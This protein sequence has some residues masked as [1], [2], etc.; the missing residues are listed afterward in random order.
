MA[1]VPRTGSLI[2]VSSMPGG[3]L[4]QMPEAAAP[5]DLPPA[6]TIASQRETKV[7]VRGPCDGPGSRRRGAV[8]RIALIAPPWLAVP[9]VSYGGTERIID[10]LA[11][12]LIEIGHDVVLLT[13]GDSTCPVPKRVTLPRAVGTD[14][15]SPAWE[16]RNVIAAYDH[17][18]EAQVDVVHDH[19]LVGPFFAR[20]FP[21]LPV[22]TTNHGPFEGDLAD[23]YR[24][25]TELIPVVAISHNQAAAAPRLRIPVEAVIHHGVHL[26]DYPIGTGRGGYAAFVGRMNPTKGVHVACQLA[27]EAAIPLRIA[28]KMRERDEHDY[29]EGCIRP[30][31]GGDIEYL[32]ELDRGDT[33]RLMGDAALSA[34]PHRLARAIWAGHGRIPGHGHTGGRNAGRSGTRDRRRRHHRLAPRRSTTVARCTPLR[35]RPRPPR[36]PGRGRA[37]VHRR[38]DGPALLDRL[39]RRHHPLAGTPPDAA[40]HG[41]TGPELPSTASSVAVRT[42]SKRRRDPSASQGPR[43]LPQR[44]RRRDK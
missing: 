3:A 2:P 25:M 38:E 26:T 14:Q 16:L 17:A 11:R 44:G 33:I 37:E 7:P 30:M 1:K 35:R 41:P 8:M 29:F 40:Q 43:S 12:G 9:P 32:G 13:T 4:L 21:R 19:T 10:T 5:A 31:L 22:V 20:R 42:R 34:Q 23:V 39:Q 18:R 15:A 28:A 36:V 6:G 24:A 27:R